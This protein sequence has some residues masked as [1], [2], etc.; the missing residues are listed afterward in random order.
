M[1]D[2]SLLNARSV[3]DRTSGP[4]GVAGDPPRASSAAGSMQ[5]STTEPPPS[6]FVVQPKTNWRLVMLRGGLLWLI[7]IPLPIILILF[8]LG[9]LS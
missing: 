6:S 1:E 7:G 5:R 3:T 8:F 9:Y 2:V 4:G